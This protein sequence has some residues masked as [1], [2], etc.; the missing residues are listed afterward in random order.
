MPTVLP[1]LLA[2]RPA[3]APPVPTGPAFDIVLLC[4]VGSVVISFGAVLATG[5]QSVRV[6]STVGGEGGD[7]A[8]L[9]AS[10]VAYF[11]PGA[12]WVGRT[13]YAVPVFGFALL[14]L[15]GGRFGPT[16]VWVEVG[17]AMWVGAVGLAE[18]ALWPAERRI[19][20]LVTGGTGA[21]G[22]AGSG[23]GDGPDGGPCTALRR[24]CVTACVASV[25][26]LC[27]LVAAIVL[28][29]AQP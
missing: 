11:A 10:L 14:G 27:V 5:V 7:R 9:P 26:I 29:V 18:W 1:V 28:M 25:A 19:Q 23:T 22:T 21:E 3:P 16:D 24:A 17:L 20:V 4:H 12:N 2:S 13:L 15:S 8:A 6:L